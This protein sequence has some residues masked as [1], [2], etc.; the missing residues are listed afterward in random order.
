MNTPTI[1]IEFLLRAVRVATDAGGDL[2]RVFR[3]AG[4]PEEILLDKTS[5]ITS[6][7]ATAFTQAT[8][9]TT[10]DELFGLGS[11]PVARGT[12][13]LLS[14]ALIHSPD[15]GTALGRISDL[16][17]VL[18]SMPEVAIS[19]SENTSR[20]EIRFSPE[21]LSEKISKRLSEESTQDA[22]KILTDFILIVMHRFSA[23]LIGKRIKLIS[24]ELPY[25]IPEKV[26]AKNYDH[27][28]GVPVNFNAPLAALEFNNEL[29]TSPVVQSEET[30][31]QYLRESPTQLFTER[32]YESTVSSKVRRIFELGSNGRA[33]SGTAI[34][35]MLAVSPAHLRRLLRQEGTSVNQLREEV[36]KDA[37]ISAL[38]RGE[39]VEQLSAQLGFSEPSA[40]RRAFK[41]WTGKTPST[42]RT[43]T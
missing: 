19:S 27:I 43:Q 29:L 31:A 32:D 17:P 23:W 39:S 15:L 35:H 7:Q 8:W 12:F 28:F 14:L 40:F 10:G 41:R 37:A 18:P 24:V 42:F 22:V 13:R 30:L 25:P 21:Q 11:A 26:M 3:D 34:A 36:L 2:S 4:I 9:T 5:F 6:E 38:R 20:I 33:A 1:P 16:L